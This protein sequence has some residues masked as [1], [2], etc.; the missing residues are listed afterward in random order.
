MSDQDAEATRQK[1]AEGVCPRC[2]RPVKRFDGEH[3]G[4]TAGVPAIVDAVEHANR[5]PTNNERDGDLEYVVE[6]GY[7]PG[8]YQHFVDLADVPPDL[9][10]SASI[11]AISELSKRGLLV[12][13]VRWDPPRLHVVAALTLNFDYYGGGR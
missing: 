11:Q 6:D 10:H 2:E 13:S 1:A 4:S 9:R 5:H 8:E 12:N 3:I 7:Y